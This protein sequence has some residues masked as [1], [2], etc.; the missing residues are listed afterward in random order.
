MAGQTGNQDIA[1]RY[2][3]AF[4]ELAKEQGQM[5]PISLDLQSLKGMVAESKD[6][7]TFMSNATLR[8]DDQMRALVALGE[9]AK[10]H[11]LTQKFLGTL[12]AKRRLAI[13]PEIIAAVQAEIARQ[14]GEVTAEVTAAYAL[15]PAQVSS[16]AAALKKVLGLTVKIELKQDADIMGGLVIRIGSQLIDS[17]V[18]AKLERLHRA[19]KNSNTSIDKKKMR[20][21]A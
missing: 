21:V 3:L 16:V 10:W 1:R 8:R 6:F 17:S 9:K 13:L 19:L 12:A 15:D 2:A 4:F 20:E 5:D 18:R 11:S 14:K 7:R